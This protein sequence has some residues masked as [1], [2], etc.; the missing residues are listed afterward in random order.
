MKPPRENFSEKI[1]LCNEM[2]FPCM[3]LFNMH[4]DDKKITEKNQE[5]LAFRMLD[6]PGFLLLNRLSKCVATW[7]HPC[8]FFHNQC[9]LILAIA[10]NK[11]P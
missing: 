1:V 6:L 7:G 3:S 9:N 8:G 11:R 2:P 4:L 10:F 5:L